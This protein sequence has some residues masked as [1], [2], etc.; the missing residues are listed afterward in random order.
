M[1]LQYPILYRTLPGLLN[2]QTG[3]RSCAEF[4]FELGTDQAIPARGWTLLSLDK[5]LMVLLLV[6]MYYLAF[7]RKSSL[8]LHS[9]KIFD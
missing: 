1:S 2:F 7:A 6:C 8:V 3:P 5:V 9:E 4:N